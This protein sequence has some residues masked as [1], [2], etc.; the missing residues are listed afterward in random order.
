[1]WG[2]SLKAESPQTEPRDEGWEKD[3]V[4]EKLKPQNF[5]LVVKYNINDDDENFT[6]NSYILNPVMYLFI[7]VRLSFFFHKN[8]PFLKKSIRNQPKMF[9]VG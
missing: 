8:Q 9:F 5:Y 3:P 1:M 4:T 6:I 2:W 7:L